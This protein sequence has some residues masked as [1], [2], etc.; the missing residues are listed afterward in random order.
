MLERDDHSAGR[1]RRPTRRVERRRRSAPQTP[2]ID[3]A[4]FI[5]P[6]RDY[7]V[8]NGSVWHSAA[9]LL[10]EPASIASMADVEEKKKKKVWHHARADA[11]YSLMPPL[12]EKEKD[13]EKEAAKAA[14]EKARN[15]A[16]AL[17]PRTP[18][19]TLSRSRK[20]SLPRI[21]RATERRRRRRRGCGATTCQPRSP[22]RSHSRR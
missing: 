18:S 16:Q 13:P 14:K 17:S 8:R 9:A 1:R 12:Q 5:G 7:S 19:Q 4:L 21:R 11:A 3:H 20:R 15:P 6:M 22:T 2:A 10:P